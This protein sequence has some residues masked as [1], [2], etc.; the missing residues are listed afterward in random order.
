MPSGVVMNDFS[1]INYFGKNGVVIFFYPKDFTFVCPSEIIAF[2]NR[3]GEFVQRGFHVIGI[4]VD[5][6]LTHK[7]WTET[8][9]EKGGIGKVEFPLVSDEDKKISKS[10]EVL[11]PEQ[12][13]L[14]GSFLIDDQQI[15][16][17]CVVN[18]FP[19]GRNID[20]MIRMIDAWLFYKEHGEVC[21]ANWNKGKKAIKPT[22]EGIAE[23]LRNNCDDLK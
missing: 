2:N 11:A 19:L 15:I 3:H 23:Y 12:L 13:A 5:S 14:R 1:L 16:R 18:D 7:S 22:A 4:S 10:Y 6:V 9:I 8:P 17:H 21:P 20:E